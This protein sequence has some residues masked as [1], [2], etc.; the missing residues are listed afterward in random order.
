MMAC[1][2]GPCMNARHAGLR[3]LVSDACQK[4]GYATLQEQLVPEFPTHR[5]MRDGVMVEEPWT[6]G[7]TVYF[8]I[9]TITTTG[10][11]DLLPKTGDTRSFTAAYAFFGVV[12]I[13]SA[14]GFLISKMM[15]AGEHALQKQARKEAM[16]PPP[17]RKGKGEGAGEGAG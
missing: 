17:V 10:Y 3:Q 16:K 7:D 2:Y 5:R 13:S 15:E 9:V 8:G 14:M 1:H 6:V 11:G 12:L 4:A